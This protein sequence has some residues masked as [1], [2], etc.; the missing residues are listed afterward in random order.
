[1]RCIR[2]VGSC[3][4]SID[5]TTERRGLMISGAPCD[6][7]GH[8]LLG[9]AAG[10]CADLGGKSDSGGDRIVVLCPG[11]FCCFSGSVLAMS[12]GSPF[13][14]Q[15]FAILVGSADDGIRAMGLEELVGINSFSHLRFVR[16]FFSPVG[17]AGCNSTDRGTV[18]P[19]CFVLVA[20]NTFFKHL[21]LRRHES[22]PLLRITDCGPPLNC[23]KFHHFPVE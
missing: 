16:L 2:L 11:P 19:E 1:M 13:F 22:F 18:L 3:E 5:D 7:P 20:W 6:E 17:P 8:F 4:R 9:P 14:D 21:S 10:F 23:A 12:C 15:N